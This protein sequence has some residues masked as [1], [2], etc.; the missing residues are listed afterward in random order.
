MADNRTARL[1]A[2]QERIR[3]E[4]M[5]DTNQQLIDRINALVGVIG[6]QNDTQADAN[7]LIQDA[8]QAIWDNT[9]AGGGGAGGAG[10]SLGYLLAQWLLITSLIIP[11]RR[12]L[13]STRWQKHL[14]RRKAK[15][16]LTIP[17]S[18]CLIFSI[19]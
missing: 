13:T 19:C 6:D 5:A 7:C 3:Q 16:S 15:P 10:G 2:R 12:V 18:N 9:A 11:P 8:F 17:K 4:Q 1:T 14:C